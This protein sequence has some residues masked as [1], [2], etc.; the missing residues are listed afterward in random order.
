[1]ADLRHRLPRARTSTLLANYLRPRASPSSTRRPCAGQR[2]NQG[3]TAIGDIQAAYVPGPDKAPLALQDHGNPGALPQHLDSRIVIRSAATSPP[4]LYEV[5]M[6]QINN[7]ARSV[8]MRT[9]YFL[10]PHQSHKLPGLFRN[11][12]NTG[13]KSFTPSASSEFRPPPSG[14]PWLAPDRAPR[15]IDGRSSRAICHRLAALH[16]AAHH[17]HAVRMAVIVPR[18]PFSFA[19]RPNSLMVTTTISPI[20]SPMS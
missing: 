9:R 5:V 15:S 3:R 7:S 6:K 10:R 16:I 20:R 12:G 8:C 13:A 17:K 19:V 18:F 4:P 1:M 11:P 14:N 2:G